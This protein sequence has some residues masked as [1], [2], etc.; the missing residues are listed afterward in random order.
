MSA[1]SAQGEVSIQTIAMPGDANW[2]GDIFGGWLV[3]QMDLAGAVCARRRAQG[4]VTT[5]SIDRMTFL[6]PVPIGSVVSCHTKILGTGTTSM[7]IQIEVWMRTDHSEPLKVT[8]GRFVFVAIDEQGNK[9][10]LPAS[11]ND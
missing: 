8:A 5:I 7:T 2:N 9:R 1:D 10:D 11:T 6:H 4:R 3:S